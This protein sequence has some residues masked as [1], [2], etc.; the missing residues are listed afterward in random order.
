MWCVRPAE[1]R[2]VVRIHCQ[3]QAQTDEENY[4]IASAIASIAW[5]VWLSV[6]LVIESRS[7]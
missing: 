7:G 4:G 6:V 3:R 5:P 1:N 2:R